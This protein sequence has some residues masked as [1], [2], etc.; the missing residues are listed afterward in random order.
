MGKLGQLNV[1]IPLCP[2]LGLVGSV[3]SI[4]IVAQ[5]LKIHYTNTEILTITVPVRMLTTA[6][7]AKISEYFWSTI[8]NRQQHVVLENIILD[9]QK[10]TSKCFKCCDNDTCE[11]TSFIYSSTAV[12]VQMCQFYVLIRGKITEEFYRPRSEGGNVFSNVCLCVC[13]STQ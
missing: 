2:H 11:N 8:S 1:L 12:I 9:Q 5:P 3:L 7:S 4:I 10:F 13:L 6:S